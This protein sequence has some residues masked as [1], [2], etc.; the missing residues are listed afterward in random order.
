MM[1]TM[2]ER[3]APAETST[4]K[5]TYR[6]RVD[7]VEL[8]NEFRI[9]AEMPGV[10]K[11][12]VELHFEKGT[13]SVRGKVAARGNSE[14]PYDV[15]EYGVGDFAREFR[16]GDGIDHESIAAELKDGVLRVRLP[17]VTAA[18]PRKIEIR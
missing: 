9:D 12:D 5:V 18:A 4:T 8:G 3:C 13:L 10:A 14:R 1:K 6:P 17:K 2:S 7:V 11:D 16:L 15:R